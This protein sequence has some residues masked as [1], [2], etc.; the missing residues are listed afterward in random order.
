MAFSFFSNKE[1]T[2]DELTPIFK[3]D[4]A[5]SDFV[6][7]DILNVYSKILVDVIERTQGL[8]DNVLKILWDSCLQSES[9]DGLISMLAKAMSDQ[10]ELFVVYR[11]DLETLVYA[12]SSE[13]NQ[14][15]EDYK[16]EG[17][18]KVGFYISF[19][20]YKKTEM[21]KLYSGLEYCSIA[22][23]NKSMNLSKAIQFKMKD[24]RG[25]VAVTDS[26]EIKKQAVEISKA[27]GD[28]K[29]VIL[30]GEDSIETGTPNLEATKSS[31]EFINQRRSFYLGL[32]ASY[33]TGEAPKGLGDSGKG[34]AKAVERGLKNYYFSIVKPVIES[35]FEI[36]TNFETED[37]DQI[38]GALEALKTFELVSDELMSAETKLSLINKLFGLPDKTKGGQPDPAQA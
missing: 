35:I 29:D 32:P 23:L 15:R 13:Q 36:K 14:I 11:P 17:K 30:D 18:S 26:S 7:N 28:G 33:I 2:N 22:S 5:Q 20:N 9:Q 4:V 16:R 10:K 12:T 3:M 8:T 19:K 37:F 38:N 6:K 1:T 34:D 31:M 27:L 21:L 25:S 24:M